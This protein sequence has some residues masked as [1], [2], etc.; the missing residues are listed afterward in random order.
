M[1]A[2]FINLCLQLHTV[3]CQCWPL[4]PTPK[5]TFGRWTTNTIIEPVNWFSLPYLYVHTTDFTTH[6]LFDYN[7]A[8][9]QLAWYEVLCSN[10]SGIS[11]MYFGIWMMIINS[12]HDLS[13]TTT[14]R[15]CIYWYEV[16]VFQELLWIK[17]KKYWG[18]CMGGVG[19]QNVIL[20]YRNWYTTCSIGTDICYEMEWHAGQIYVDVMIS[21][22]VIKSKLENWMCL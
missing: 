22:F 9:L 14:K 19:I 18:L 4:S 7:V 6:Y 10:G 2:Y 16:G 8:W 5:V 11:G 17:R 1:L 15:K 3:P 20:K 13:Q 12:L 21:I